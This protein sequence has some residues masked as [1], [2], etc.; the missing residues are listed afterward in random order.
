MSP[1]CSWRHIIR[2]FL[3]IFENNKTSQD[4]LELTRRQSLP[5]AAFD[6]VPNS[7]HLIQGATELLFSVHPHPSG[8]SIHLL[9]SDLPGTT[10]CSKMMQRVFAKSCSRLLVTFSHK[11]E[12]GVSDLQN[13]NGISFLP[14]QDALAAWTLSWAQ[15]LNLRL[16]HQHFFIPPTSLL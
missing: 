1:Q 5:M 10:Q 16:R 8:E 13:G 12:A 7:E 2:G 3:S 14:S 6:V 11:G 4:D 9:R 15:S